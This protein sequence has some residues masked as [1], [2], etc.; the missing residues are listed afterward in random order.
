[1][2]PILRLSAP[3]TCLRCRIQSAARHSRF[4]P[5]TP[6]IPLRTTPQS[7]RSL[8]SRPSAPAPP[9]S[10]ASSLSQATQSA[11][12]Q[13]L[14]TAATAP[15]TTTSATNLP[16]GT[17]VRKAAAAP[18][19]APRKAALT[20]TPRAVER[21]RRM[22]SNPEKPQYLKVGTK[23]RGCSGLSYSLD[24]VAAPGRFD[25]VVEQDGVKVVVDSKA[26]FSLIGS[27]MDF[28]DDVLHSEFVFNNPNVK[29][30]CGCGESFMV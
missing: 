30:T 29:E 15:S 12:T 24:Y 3:S 11:R 17:S 13:P 16:P 20:I 28:V 8:H 25:E 21:L 9:L 18:R 26:L 1:M 4:V 10:Q 27:E 2:S 23:K 14:S 19:F 5:Q 7:F 22:L 6:A